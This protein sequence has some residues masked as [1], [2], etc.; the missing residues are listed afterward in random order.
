MATNEQILNV[1]NT[2]DQSSADVVAIQ[3]ALAQTGLPEPQVEE[4]LLLIALA[5]CRAAYR[6][7]PEMSELPLDADFLQSDLYQ[8]AYQ[9]ASSCAL[10]E[11]IHVD[12]FNTIVKFSPEYQHFRR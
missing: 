7:R 1:I 5:F 12:V 11:A 6:F 3:R 8:A 2:L 10:S 9:V 4:S